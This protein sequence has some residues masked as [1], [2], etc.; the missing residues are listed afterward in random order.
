[1]QKHIC[2]A[3]LIVGL[4]CGGAAFAAEMELSNEAAAPDNTTIVYNGSYQG[5]FIIYPNNRMRSNTPYN[6][7]QQKMVSGTI[8][9]EITYQGN[10]F[11]GHWQATGVIDQS[12]TFV[13][14]RDGTRCHLEDGSN[15]ESTGG[16]STFQCTATEFLGSIVNPPENPAE[17]SIVITA[18][19]DRPPAPQVAQATQPPPATF[20][21]TPPE[22]RAPARELSP[23]EQNVDK[24][25]TADSRSWLFWR[26]DIG[27]VKNTKYLE[28]SKKN[29]SALIYSEYTYNGGQAGWVKLRIAE[30][31]VA[32]I[33]FWNEGAC[34]PL[35]QP[36]S[37]RIVGAMMQAMV[38]DIMSGGGNSGGDDADCRNMSAARC[39][40]IQ[41]SRQKTKAFDDWHHQ[42]E[43]LKEQTG[44]N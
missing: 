8:R 41:S 33:E 32:C 3:G 19:A 35:G 4:W 25:I 16:S 6:G 9:F 40:E 37:H 38:F 13:G 2:A 18:I 15:V 36:P 12:K 14:T 34:R 21:S 20:Q 29:N 7:G 30:G 11:R 23:F 26:Y 24:V 1:M 39:A 17:G 44:Q 28:R 42:Q 22:A 10:R 43:M 5:N 31:K 27:S